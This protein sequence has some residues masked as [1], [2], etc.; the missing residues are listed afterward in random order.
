MTDNKF[1][2]GY[3]NGISVFGNKENNRI[4]I[5]ASSTDLGSNV[6]QETILTFTIQQM[7]EVQKM[8][9]DTIKRFVDERNNK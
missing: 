4:E 6:R 2:M 5:H 1:Y 9:D 8:L 7:L 3:V